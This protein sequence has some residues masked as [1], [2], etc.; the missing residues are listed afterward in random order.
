[1]PDD[2]STTNGGQNDTQLTV[3]DRLVGFCL[4][5]VVFA[6]FVALGVKFGEKAQ[7]FSAPQFFERLRKLWPALANNLGGLIDDARRTPY[8]SYA[9][10][11]AV[12]KEALNFFPMIVAPLLREYKNLR[13]HAPKAV[14]QA[15]ALICASFA[16]GFWHQGRKV[17]PNRVDFGNFGV[18]TGKPLTFTVNFPDEYKMSNGNGAGINAVKPPDD[19]K[20]FLR[21]LG[22]ALAD[23]PSDVYARPAI[24]VVGFASQEGA[25]YDDKLGEANVIAANKRADNVADEIA[26][27]FCTKPELRKP[28]VCERAM[29]SNQLPIDFHI[30]HW[31]EY[32]EMIE[33]L[34]FHDTIPFNRY[35]GEVGNLTR[36]AEISITSAGQCEIDNNTLVDRKDSKNTP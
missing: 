31:K 3:K 9:I 33:G 36:R 13:S 20:N 30:T 7:T 16:V 10:L 19:A 21:R 14:L 15:S 34:E 22:R 8:T 29:N 1:M 26:Q 5:C 24:S 11:A 28:K 6:V 25:K 12:G 27:T 23:C 17:A 18:S 4:M 32:K 35:V 2:E